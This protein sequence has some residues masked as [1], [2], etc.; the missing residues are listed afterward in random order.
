MISLS[1]SQYVR[2]LQCLKLI[3][4]YKYKRELQEVSKENEFLFETGNAVGDMAKKLFDGGVEIK[5]EKDNFDNMIE[6]TKE[7]IN[8][9]AEIIYE[10]AFKEKNIFVMADILVKKEYGY[11]LY[12]VKAST[13]IKDYQIDDVSIQWF[14]ISEVLNLKKAFI[15]HINNQYE[16]N[17]DLEIDKLFNIEDVTSLVKEKQANIPEKL[18]EIEDI[19]NDKEHE[20]GIDIG[21][22]CINPF[23][24]DFY[25]YCWKDI[26]K[27]SV[28]EL[29]RLNIDKKFSLYDEGI[30]NLTD[31]KEDSLTKTQKVQFD[32]V[33]NQSIHINRNIIKKFLDKLEFPLNFLDF[34]TFSEPI[35]RFDQQRPYQQIPFQYSLHIL[36]KN[37]NLTHLEF[38]ADENSDPRN[39]FIS[40]LLNSLTDTGTILAYNQSF[41]ISRI[42]YLADFNPE[43]KD[44]LSALIDRFEDLL[45]PFRCLGVYYPDF[46]GSFSIKSV[47]PALFP[48][49]DDL[50][51][52]NL[53]SIQNG[54]D[55]MNIYPK[56]HSVTDNSLKNQIKQDLLAYCKLD[57]FAMVKIY[58]KL[59][60]YNNSHHI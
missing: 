54:G 34:E 40:S 55:A 60:E 27:H 7:Y 3:W 52:D 41:E 14:V 50:K 15:V 45:E 29:Y 2:S 42:K 13:E 22:H 23:Q 10:A 16:R 38:L 20:P 32:C 35:P 49:D 44:E 56:L 30:V 11:S 31:V 39:P 58:Y 48:D 1:K 25:N 18:K 8:N 51:Y 33:K 53:G 21:T 19:L 57:T 5:F 6:K 26:P 47:L 28:F 59:L 43:Y 24:C 9:G 37:E 4:L 36:D 12:E 17:G 46:Y